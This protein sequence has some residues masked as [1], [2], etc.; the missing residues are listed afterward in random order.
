MS[1]SV[2]NYLRGLLVPDGFANS[3]SRF[4]R[5]QSLHFAA[6]GFGGGHLLAW[7]TGSP[8][9]ALGL[10]IL[11]YAAWEGW[12]LFGRDDGKWWDGLKDTAFT[13]AG[14]FVALPAAIDPQVAILW[15][16]ALH[17]AAGYLRRKDF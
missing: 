11:A 5:N 3:P 6:V 10:L 13:H 2:S 15:L 1:I 16:A 14:A 4:L 17:G 7:L 8:V 9:A 12:Q